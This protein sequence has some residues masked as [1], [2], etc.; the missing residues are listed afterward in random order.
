MHVRKSAG[1]VFNWMCLNRCEW[2]HVC[3]N[4]VENVCGLDSMGE[5]RVKWRGSSLWPHCQR[6]N[7]LSEEQYSETLQCERKRLETGCWIRMDLSLYLTICLIP[8][9]HYILPVKIWAIFIFLM[10]LETC[11]SQC[12]C[13]NVSYAHQGCIY[14]NKN[15]Y[16]HYFICITF[17]YW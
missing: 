5:R 12:L 8:H 9:E 6:N 1:L 4:Y 14:L 16:Y 15:Y 11:W 13:F 17:F 7:K 3:V 10:S 2:V